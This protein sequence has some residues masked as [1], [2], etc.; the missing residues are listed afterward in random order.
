ML[1]IIPAAG[2]AT[3]I[4]GIPKFLLP[5]EQDNFLLKFHT[6]ELK[7]NDLVLK[8]VIA[9]SSE[10]YKAVSRLNL[11]AELE[12]VETKT[13]NETVLRILELF[14]NEDEYVLSMPDTYFND[15]DIF[16]KMYKQFLNTDCDGVL[17]LWNIRESQIGK[18]GQCQISDQYINKTVDKNFDC[19]LP[20]SWGTVMWSNKLNTYIDYQQPHIGYMVN[21]SIEEGRNFRYALS[22]G[23]YFDC[24]T[25]SEYKEMLLI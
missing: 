15:I 7:I 1:H 3:R 13:M 11:N 25:F 6:E 10:N 2:T 9:V 14:P 19:K 5:I 21:P 18:L 8:K 24:G 17:G 20:H 23:S 4:S 22:K 16:N 12:V